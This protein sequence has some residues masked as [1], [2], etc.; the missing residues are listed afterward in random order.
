MASFKFPTTE[1]TFDELLHRS[2]V[3]PSRR[4][5]LP[6]VSEAP[7]DFA[8]PT[9]VIF[10]C[11]DFRF[12]PEEFFNLRKGEAFVIKTVGSNVRPNLNNLL[13]LDT[14]LNNDLREIIVIHHEV[15]KIK[16]NIKARVSNLDNEIDELTFYMHDGQNVREDLKYFRESLYIRKDLAANARGFVF[17]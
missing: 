16:D 1:V 3:I 11:C 17:Y 9:I 8:K 2:E 14:L 4:P 7:K 6:F 10:S 13:Y 12:S 15:E 5:P